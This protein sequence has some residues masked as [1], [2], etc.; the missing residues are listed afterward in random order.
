MGGTLKS[1]YL[2]GSLRNP[3]VPKLAN[4]IRRIGLEVFDDWY[5]PGPRADDFWRDYEKQRGHSYAQALKGWAGKH[6]FEFDRFHLDRC[7]GAVMLMPAGKSCHLE[8]GYVIGCGKPGYIL[9]DKEPERYDVMYQFATEVFF[10]KAKL[11]AKLK[12]HGPF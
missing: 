3:E 9:F 1:I 8:F 4:A 7:D 11:I 12:T 5:S 2:I 10:S 6:I